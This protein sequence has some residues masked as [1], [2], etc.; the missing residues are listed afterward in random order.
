MK[1]LRPAGMVAALVAVIP[2]AAWASDT[3]DALKLA[4]RIASHG[5]QSSAVTLHALPADF[6]RTIPLPNA[7]LLGSVAERPAQTSAS[8]GTTITVSAHGSSLYYDAV[9][10][11]TVLAAYADTL[12]TAGWLEH[13]SPLAG[14]GGFATR[15]PDLA[16]WCRAGDHP[17]E[18]VVL[19]GADPTAIIVDVQAGAHTARMLCDA[20]QF[21]PA[22]RPSPLPTFV[23]APGVTMEAAGPATDGTTTAARLAS[24]LAAPAV[25]DSFAKQL[26]GAGWTPRAKDQAHG[27]VSQTFAK[28]VDGVRYVALLS[29]YALDATRYVAIADVRDVNR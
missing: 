21:M 27:L 5:M 3:D 23:A 20:D 13:R 16:I 24:A 8:F 22:L 7:T 10:R 2:I 6:P 29:L 28:T 11:D 26:V 14:Q 15:M 17:A 9:D 12:R 19:P 1:R 4:G 25:F 18:I